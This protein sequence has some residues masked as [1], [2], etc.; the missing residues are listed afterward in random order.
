MYNNQGSELYALKIL[1]YALKNIKICGIICSKKLE[2][3]CLKNNK[4]TTD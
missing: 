1:K 3:N 4:L 2:N